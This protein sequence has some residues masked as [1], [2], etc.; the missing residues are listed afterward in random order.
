M[1]NIE[2]KQWRS[3]GRLHPRASFNLPAIHSGAFNDMALFE[4]YFRATGLFGVSPD[5]DN[6]EHASLHQI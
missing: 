2:W 3:M 1:A 5:S 4:V 6:I